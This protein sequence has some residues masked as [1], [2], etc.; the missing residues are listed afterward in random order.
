M[1][2][3]VSIREFSS[4]SA[5][6][7]TL[8]D[9]DHPQRASRNPTASLDDRWP[10]WTPYYARIQPPPG[11]KEA[12]S[13]RM[14]T[15]CAG[16]VRCLLLVRRNLDPHRSFTNTSWDSGSRL[17]VRYTTYSRVM[18]FRDSRTLF[19]IDRVTNGHN[20]LSGDVCLR[21]STPIDS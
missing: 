20:V 14:R 5:W 3:N 8:R 9:G 18:I 17:D 1:K 19:G 13:W 10:G 12:R 6:C 11:K 2:V 7:P 21:L 4:L 16:S 15:L